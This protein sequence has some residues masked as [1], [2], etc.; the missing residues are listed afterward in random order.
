M[1]DR[2]RLFRHLDPPE[3]PP[4]RHDDARPRPALFD[5]G[6]M[7]PEDPDWHMSLDRCLM[8]CTRNLTGAGAGGA[9]GPDIGHVTWCA[10]HAAEGRAEVD[11]RY[12][13]ANPQ[14]EP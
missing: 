7:S 3:P 5:L 12:R 11:R 9:G 4:A 13:L 6:P 2:P 1:T 10:K 8:G 14:H